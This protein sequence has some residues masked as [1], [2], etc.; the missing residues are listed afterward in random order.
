MFRL[1]EKVNNMIWEFRLGINTRGITGVDTADDEHIHYGTIPYRTI[2]RILDHL[3]MTND[4][5]FVDLGAGKG[6]VSC[7]AAL[8]TIQESIA[9]EC[10]RSLSEVA[11]N[12]SHRLRPDH[13]RINIHSIEAQ[14][15]DYS[16]GTIFY[17][18]HPFGP[19]TLREVLVQLCDGLRRNRRP[20]RIVYVNP[21]HKD[22]FKEFSW[23]TEYE[24]WVPSEDRSPDH[25]VS[26][27]LNTQ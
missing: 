15:F 16:I 5:I 18:F 20:V 3:H 17:L 7:C 6:R 13:S 8:R 26:W 10:S 9:V 22:I 14:H 2:N 25:P 12:N 1:F 24:Y 27:W 4:T 23:L 21:V 11:R 19:E